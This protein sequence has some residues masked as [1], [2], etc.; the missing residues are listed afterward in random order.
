MRCSLAIGRQHDAAGRARRSQAVIAAANLTEQ[1]FLA[2]QTNVRGFLIRGNADV[3]ADYQR[4]RTRLARCGHS[5]RALVGDNRVAVGGWPTTSA[6]R[7][8]PTSMTTPIR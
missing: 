4:A 1:R 5:L 3:L 8:S 2:V 7:R 6:S